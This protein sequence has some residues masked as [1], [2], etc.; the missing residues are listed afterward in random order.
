MY[1]GMLRNIADPGRMT[2][3]GRSIRIGPGSVNEKPNRQ[4]SSTAKAIDSS[5]VSEH[6]TRGIIL[7]KAFSTSDLLTK[8]TH[9][10]F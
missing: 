2:D 1:P 4:N 8:P 7:M 3:P 5:G 6:S 10:R 9:K